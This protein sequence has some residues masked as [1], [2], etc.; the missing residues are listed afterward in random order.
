MDKKVVTLLEKEQM[1][2]N[3]LAISDSDCFKREFYPLLTKNAGQQRVGLGIA[4]M[5]VEAIFSFTEDNGPFWFGVLAS[6][7]D[8]YIDALT[9]DAEASKIAKD[10]FAKISGS[11]PT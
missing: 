10:Y 7:A 6:D 4:M 11:S 9:D 2:R 8:R 3:L 1:T 5:L